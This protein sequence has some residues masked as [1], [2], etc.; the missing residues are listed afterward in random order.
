[1]YGGETTVTFSEPTDGAG[2]R[3][4][5]LALAAAIEL[6]GHPGCWLATLATDGE[7]GPNDGAGAIVNGNTVRQAA[8][9]GLDAASYLTQH[10]SYTFFDKL[11]KG[12]VRIG[13]TGTNVNDVTLL[14]KTTEI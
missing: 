2:G 4:Q 14:L 12:H 9:R 7:D 8:N 3:N 1:M 10:D 11:G 5:E 6:D 13:S